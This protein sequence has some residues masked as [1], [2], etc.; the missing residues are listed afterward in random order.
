MKKMCL[1]FITFTVLATFG[2]Q[3]QEGRGTTTEKWR[4]FAVT[5]IRKE[6]VLAELTRETADGETEGSGEVSV[7]GLTYP[8]LFQVAGFVRR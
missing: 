5:D 1:A 6:T 7:A 2:V 8:A 4:C 3:A